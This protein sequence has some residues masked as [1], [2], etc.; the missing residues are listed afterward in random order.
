MESLTALAEFCISYGWGLWTGIG[1]GVQKYIGIVLGI[2]TQ[3]VL[4]ELL[5]LGVG[6][7]LQTI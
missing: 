7:T 3:G 5:A 2:C 4:N 1:Y 6:D